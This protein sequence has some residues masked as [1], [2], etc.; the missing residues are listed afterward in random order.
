MCF[1]V[2]G[3]RG[4]PDIVVGTGAR[5]IDM[6]QAELRVIQTFGMATLLKLNPI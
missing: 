3:G 4:G 1:V 5:S 2:P 6:E